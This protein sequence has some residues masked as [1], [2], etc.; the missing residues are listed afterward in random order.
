MGI[1]SGARLIAV[2]NIDVSTRVN[3]DTPVS[4]EQVEQVIQNAYMPL[5]LRFY[6]PVLEQLPSAPD[7]GE[8][9]VTYA[10]GSKLGVVIDSKKDGELGSYV[11]SIQS[12]GVSASN[13]VEVGDQIV[14]VA[15]KRVDGERHEETLRLI[16][17][18]E[19][20]LH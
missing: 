8:Y 19:R 4:W 5:R 6:Q 15:G 9:D 10:E 13:G 18:S 3:R 16:Q 1:T 7:G 12:D 14:G 20:P 2:G 17:Y 11:V